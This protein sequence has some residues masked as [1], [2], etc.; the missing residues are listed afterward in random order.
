M[1]FCTECGARHDDAATVCP[2]CGQPIFAPADDDL[3]DVLASLDDLDLPEPPEASTDRGGDAEEPSA[4]YVEQIQDVRGAIA[5]QSSALSRITDLTWSN[6]TA[7]QIRDELT[8][9]LVQLRELRPPPELDGA[10]DD[11]RLGAE[12]LVHGFVALVEAL[13]R[14]NAEAEVGAAQEE[15]T[16]ATERFRRGADV[17]NDFLIAHE[18]PAHP[19]LDEVDDAATPDVEL[20][21]PKELLRPIVPLEE[22]EP[23]R[24][25]AP[26][27][28]EAL[29]AAPTAV[30]AA[31]AGFGEA[32]APSTPPA[33]ARGPDEGPRGAWPTLGDAGTDSLLLEI[34]GGWVRGR[35]NVYDAIERAVR[36]AVADAL[37]GAL[38][39][40]LRVEEEAR[41][42]LQ[43]TSSERNRL[44][45]EVESLRRETLQ[46]QTEAADLRRTLNELER[47]RQTAHDRR[48]QMFQEAEA[49]RAQLLGEIEQLGS[50]L[51]TMRRNIVG[52]LNMSA[53]ATGDLSQAAQARA[54]PA[55]SAVADAGTRVAADAGAG[56]GAVAGA[57]ATSARATPTPRAQSVPRPPE[58]DPPLPEPGNDNSTQ[59][60]ITGL[61]GVA[62]NL[63]L[64]KAIRALEGV[65]VEGQ[66]Q[67]RNGVLVLNLRHDPAM[68][69]MGA[70]L[71]LPVGGLR[72]E[73]M[74]EPGVIEFQ[75]A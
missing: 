31:P 13:N 63:Q 19:P 15:I 67:F 39:I 5:R 33:E 14:P 66:A 48:Q 74:P 73:G 59:V 38:Q 24:A 7:A 60:R 11:F 29:P 75:A 42:T 34:E 25:D 35:P 43:R 44:L 54:A 28:R 53:Q 16:R 37:R 61:Q 18:A 21:L 55:P 58:R 8:A 57:P 9:A 1:P 40:R 2:K 65:E 12:H 47:E 23:P 10:H 51:D 50:Q 62:K 17:L 32:A 36:G 26:T 3:D 70:L 20:D 46:L 68:D 56:G 49:H 69:L 30:R 45:D 64:Q 4:D 41:A 6:P 72:F 52:L 22:D 71:D 27:D